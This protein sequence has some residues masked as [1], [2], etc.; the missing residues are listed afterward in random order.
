M[1]SAR[2]KREHAGPARHS[3]RHS[4]GRR[5]RAENCSASALWLLCRRTLGCR[6]LP[7][8]RGY[9]ATSTR[10]RYP[11][12][13]ASGGRCG[14]DQRQSDESANQAAENADRRRAERRPAARPQGRRGGDTCRERLRRPDRIGS[15]HP[16]RNGRCA[17]AAARGPAQVLARVVSTASHTTRCRRAAKA[18]L[19]GDCG[20]N[21]LS[22]T[23]RRRSGRLSRFGCASAR[24]CGRPFRPRRDRT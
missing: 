22:R 10:R 7:V 15:R 21:A 12:F 18:A 8:A 11:R 1:R 24:L 14:L 19:A 2:K 16:G 23:G 3:A 6:Q 20:T 13:A 5:D 9:A 17:G 4:D